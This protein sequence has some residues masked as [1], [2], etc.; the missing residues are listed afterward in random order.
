M[1]IKRRTKIESLTSVL[2]NIVAGSGEVEIGKI[3]ICT[4]SGDSFRVAYEEVKDLKVGDE[5]EII[6]NHG[7]K[8][9]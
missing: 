6:I 9:E 2:S 8:T 7:E 4:F 1:N 5:I 3:E